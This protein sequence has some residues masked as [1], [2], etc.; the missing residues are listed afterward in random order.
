LEGRSLSDESAALSF[1]LPWDPLTIGRTMQA[2][3]N[4]LCVPATFVLGRHIRLTRSASA[5]AALLLMAVPEFQELA[6]R[7][8]TDSQATFLSLVYLSALVAFI[9]RPAWLSGTLGLI[10]LGLLLLTKESAAVTFA[11]IGR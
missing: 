9:R 2:V 10:C 4:A 5:V 8:W 3:F 11:Q 1:V 7:F 6:W